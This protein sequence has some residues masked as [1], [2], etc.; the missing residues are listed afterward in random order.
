[1]V[2]VF[3]RSSNAGS[4]FLC[5][6]MQGLPY[7]IPVW[8]RPRGTCWDVNVNFS[9]IGCSRARTPCART[10]YL[11]QCQWVCL[12]VRFPERLAWNPLEYQRVWLY[13]R[14]PQSSKPNTRPLQQVRAIALRDAY[15]GLGAVPKAGGQATLNIAIAE[16]VTKTVGGH[17]SK[18]AIRLPLERY[19]V[20]PSGWYPGK[21]DQV[22]FGPSPVLN[23]PPKHPLALWPQERQTTSATP[24][25][26]SAY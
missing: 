13:L 14:K 4:P 24:S 18:E 11:Q 7:P 20:D 15:T 3:G 22:K 10:H 21:A 5:A 17:P 26:N 25:R 6:C 9:W 23:M 19:D 2:W 16:R 8:V 1:M 12:F